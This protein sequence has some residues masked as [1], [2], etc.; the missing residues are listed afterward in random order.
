MK[1]NNIRL[2]VSQFDATF[3]FYRDILRLPVV[4]GDLGQNY[5]QF[6]T[7]GGQE[8]SIFSKNLMALAIGTAYLPE[9]AQAQDRA[10]LIFNVENVDQI[11]EQLQSQGVP[12]LHPPLDY[13]HWGVRATHLR[14]PEGNLV[15]LIADLPRE[16]CSDKLKND[17]K[18]Y[19]QA[20]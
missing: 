9:H 20:Q 14:D 8:L 17:F 4:W 6:K 13:S 7:G 12:F 3:L 18:K 10:V 11:Y 5:A 16:Q 15:E 1:L 2:L 19:E